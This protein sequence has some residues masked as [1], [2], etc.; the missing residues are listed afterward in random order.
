M[1][2]TLGLTALTIPALTYAWRITR[3]SDRGLRD[4]LP[5]TWARMIEMAATAVGYWDGCREIACSRTKSAP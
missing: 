5:F 1:I 4:L 3:Y 2:G